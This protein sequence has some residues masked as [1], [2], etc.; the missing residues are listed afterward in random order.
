[1]HHGALALLQNDRRT[2]FYAIVC[3]RQRWNMALGSSEH[4][5]WLCPINDKLTLLK[6]LFFSFNM[7]ILH[8]SFFSAE[9][10][11][12]I[13]SRNSCAVARMK[14]SKATAPHK[15]VLFQCHPGCQACAA[16][17][18]QCRRKGGPAVAGGHTRRHV[19][20]HTETLTSALSYSGRLMSAAARSCR[21]G[22]V[23][24]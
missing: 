18:T 11:L 14:G 24:R 10:R 17:V 9:S 16:A 6:P 3:R 20:L 23:L 7:K 8:F 5:V 19:R 13:A 4:C 21:K 1:M 2:C 15:Q 12:R 22:T